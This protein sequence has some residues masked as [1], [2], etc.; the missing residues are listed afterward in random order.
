MQNRTGRHRTNGVLPRLGSLKCPITQGT[1]GLGHGTLRIAGGKKM[2][3]KTTFGL[4]LRSRRLNRSAVTI[5]AVAADRFL[6]RLVHT[7]IRSAYDLTNANACGSS[8][9][10]KLKG[11]RCCSS[12]SAVPN[13]E[14]GTVINN[15]MQRHRRCV[16]LHDPLRNAIHSPDEGSGPSEGEKS[17][18]RTE[19]GNRTLE[20]L[21]D[22]VHAPLRYNGFQN[23]YTP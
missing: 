3:S 5:A 4:R 19:R 9:V 22:M 20:F 12:S 7:S 2:G 21:R 6:Q 18:L 13:A 8:A 15:P 17:F 1:K 10:V 23:R 16:K 14:L 11:S